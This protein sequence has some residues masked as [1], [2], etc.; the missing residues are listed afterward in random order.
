MNRQG[1]LATLLLL[2]L[3]TAC[4]SPSVKETSGLGRQ[5]SRG[6]VAL[7]ASLLAAPG[8][9]GAAIDVTVEAGKVVLTGFVE[10]DAQRQRAA[11]IVR[12]QSGDVEIDNRLTVK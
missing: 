11:D 3:L 2:G 6:A 12:E 4:A 7:K 1:R 8:L 9:A 10:T 5:D